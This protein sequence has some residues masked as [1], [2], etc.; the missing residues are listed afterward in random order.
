M[1]IMKI[2]FHMVEY[3]GRGDL[4]LGVRACDLKVRV[5]GREGH[6]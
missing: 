5:R 2:N 3:G 1:K 4:W 6:K